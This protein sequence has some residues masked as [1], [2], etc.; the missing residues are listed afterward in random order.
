MV[1]TAAVRR[2]FITANAIHL[3][4]DFSQARGLLH[5]LVEARISQPLAIVKD[6]RSSE[7]AGSGSSA[8]LLQLFIGYFEIFRS[9]LVKWII[10]FKID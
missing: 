9:T 10:G 6:T 8:V 2:R 7:A 4:E 1:S 3:A 5:G